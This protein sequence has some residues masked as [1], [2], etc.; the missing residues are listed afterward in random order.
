MLILALLIQGCSTQTKSEQDAAYDP[1]IEPEGHA[2]LYEVANEDEEMTLVRNI[3]NWAMKNGYSGILTGST[4]SRSPLRAPKGF[5]KELSAGNAGLDV[6][7]SPSS[8][9]TG[10]I[11]VSF[12][13]WGK[14]NSAE[15]KRELA[16]FRVRFPAGSQSP[17]R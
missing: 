7:V 3:E 14:P 4:D 11:E 2:L 1:Q 9:F 12:K 15:M 8:V 6:V 10:K 17:S 13:D 5:R 16:A